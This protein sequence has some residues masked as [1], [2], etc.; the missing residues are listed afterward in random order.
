MP[1]QKFQLFDIYFISNITLEDVENLSA[2]ADSLY[3]PGGI[4]LQKCPS[5]SVLT[6]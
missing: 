1:Y 2:D 5:L 3:V 4:N 6:S